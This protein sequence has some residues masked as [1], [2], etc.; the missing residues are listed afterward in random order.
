[1]QRAQKSTQHQFST[2]IL[3]D[4]LYFVLPVVLSLQSIVT[5]SM[6]LRKFTFGS[7]PPSNVVSKAGTITLT[8]AP[9][10]G[11]TIASF[12]HRSFG[13]NGTTASNNDKDSLLTNE[14]R[15]TSLSG[16]QSPNRFTSIYSEMQRTCRDEIET[17]AKCVMMAQQQQQ[18]GATTSTMD[19]HA[20][21]GTTY[22]MCAAEFAP[23]KECFRT[24]R[25]QLRQQQQP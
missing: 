19:H 11:I 14:P 1:M 18:R 22:H 3:S 23:V 2:S 4:V 13:T 25:R 17:Y 24:V 12:L 7:A 20:N 10:I 5:T 21:S 6:K 8:T 16:K 15:L 9:F